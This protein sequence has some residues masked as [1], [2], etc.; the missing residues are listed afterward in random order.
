[1]TEESW[2]FPMSTPQP[3]TPRELLLSDAKRNG[4]NVVHVFNPVHPYGGLTIAFRKVKPNQRSTNMVDIAVAT[5]SYAD[6]FNR[7]IGTEIALTKW[8]NCETIQLPLSD[9]LPNEDLNGLVKRRFGALFF[10]S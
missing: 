7:K 8:F 3:K 5:C 1:M 2:P 9:G 6:T 10:S 4:V